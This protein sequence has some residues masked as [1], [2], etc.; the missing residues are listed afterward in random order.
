MADLVEP[1]RGLQIK[2]GFVGLVEGEVCF[3]A[4]EIRCHLHVI[5]EKMLVEE[6][7]LRIV[8]FA[9]DDGILRPVNIS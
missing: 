3:A 5:I 4:V 8:H 7:L 9:F 6:K 2:N 1:L